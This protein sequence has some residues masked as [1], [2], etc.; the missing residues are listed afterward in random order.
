MNEKYLK[1]PLSFSFNFELIQLWSKYKILTGN[2]SFIYFFKVLQKLRVR[3]EFKNWK[4]PKPWANEPR[5]GGGTIEGV[6]DA[7]Q[8]V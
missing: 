8:R 5:G 1:P 3:Y 7:W 4:H 6:G 2:Y